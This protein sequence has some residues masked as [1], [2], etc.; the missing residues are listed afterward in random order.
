MAMTIPYEHATAVPAA[1]KK[2]KVDDD[3]VF[4]LKVKR[5]SEHAI[6]P[7]KGSSQA[8]GYDLYRYVCRLNF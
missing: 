8:A 3:G 2:A 6:V 4:S 7:T 1:P 5:L